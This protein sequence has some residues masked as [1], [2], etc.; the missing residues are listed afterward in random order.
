LVETS[1]AVNAILSS[2]GFLAMITLMIV[3]ARLFVRIG[4][5]V[6]GGAASADE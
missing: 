2:L 6:Q 5:R 1:S 3:R 4:D